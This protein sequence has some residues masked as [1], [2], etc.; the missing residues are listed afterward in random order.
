M[1]ITKTYLK[2]I[3]KESIEEVRGFKNVTPDTKLSDLSPVKPSSQ[4]VLT[5]GQEY[6]LATSGESEGKDAMI[7]LKDAAGDMVSVMIDTKKISDSLQL[8]AGKEIPVFSVK[9]DKQIGSLMKGPDGKVKFSEKTGK[10]YTTV[11]GKDE[12]DDEEGDE[13]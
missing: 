8:P 7:R 4:T 12:T 2:Q 6:E 5:R 1:K 11:M 9:T 13:V 3:I 10:K